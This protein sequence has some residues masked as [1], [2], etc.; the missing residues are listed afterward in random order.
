VGAGCRWRAAG[1][2]SLRRPI[3]SVHGPSL[4][5]EAAAGQH[6]HHHYCPAALLRRIFC[7]CRP[8]SSAP[9]PGGGDQQQGGAATAAGQKARRLLLRGPAPVSVVILEPDGWGLRCS[10]RL[11]QAP[12]CWWRAFTAAEGC[13]VHRSMSLVRYM[14]APCRP[15]FTSGC[16][17]RLCR[18]P[19][20]AWRRRR[21]PW[22]AGPLLAAAGASALAGRTRWSGQGPT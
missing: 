11:V 20:A 22:L 3:E 12:A 9:L 16:G 17:A 1:W 13:S 8:G 21:P 7:C 14:H 15:G 19:A 2:P 10:G 5:R 6:H 4:P 18:A